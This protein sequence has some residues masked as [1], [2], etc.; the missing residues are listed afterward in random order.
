MKKKSRNGAFKILKRLC[1]GTFAF[2]YLFLSNPKI[3]E[4][5]I[6]EILTSK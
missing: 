2:Y 1:L 5:N 4:H 6:H 3:Q